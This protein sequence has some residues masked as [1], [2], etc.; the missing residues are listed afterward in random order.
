MTRLAWLAL[1][2]TLAVTGCGRT[3]GGTTVTPLATAPAAVIQ[4]AELVPNST[5]RL[6]IVTAV[7]PT[8]GY[9][10]AALVPRAADVPGQLAFDFVATPPP[11]PAPVLTERSREIT[12]ATYLSPR[13]SAGIREITVSGAGNARAIR[14]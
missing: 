1:A 6:L 2:T 14:F 8:Q 13:D 11:G 10:N 7:A 3:G 5:G 9:W 12:V 4:S